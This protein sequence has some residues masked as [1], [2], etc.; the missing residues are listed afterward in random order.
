MQVILDQDSFYSWFNQAFLFDSKTMLGVWV[1]ESEMR[2]LADTMA[3]QR[4]PCLAM[5]IPGSPHVDSPRAVYVYREQ[6]AD[7]L[8][9]LS[10]QESCTFAGR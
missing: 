10:G 6:I 7:W 2:R 5:M 3:P 4:Y 1:S 9:Q 8:E